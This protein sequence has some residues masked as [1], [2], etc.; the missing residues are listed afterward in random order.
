M[1]GGGAGGWS[2]STVGGHWVGVFWE[3]RLSVMTHASFDLAPADVASIVATLTRAPRP[4]A[5]HPEWGATD[6]PT[7]GFTINAQLPS[8][9]VSWLD[10]QDG[11]QWRVTI[12]GRAGFIASG[13]PSEA[14]EA[15]R[16]R[17]V[18]RVSGPPE[19]DPGGCGVPAAPGRGRRPA[20]SVV[21]V[22]L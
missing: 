7:W 16:R 21:P 13:N 18:R 17:A 11:P 9:D 5:H 20:L 19:T 22:H 14:M 15:V 10:T 4:N 12:G 2:I 1:S 6:Q 8:G 3:S